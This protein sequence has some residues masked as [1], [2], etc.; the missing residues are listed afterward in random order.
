MKAS[1]QITKLQDELV[2]YA[3][4]GDQ[5][6][7]RRAFR[8]LLNAGCSRQEIVTKLL[9]ASQAAD[10]TPNA[11]RDEEPEAAKTEAQVS[12]SAQEPA[13]SDPEQNSENVAELPATPEPASEISARD[14]K[15]HP[16]IS[17]AEPAEPRPEGQPNLA[18]SIM[19]GS[20]KPD[21]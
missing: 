3:E 16:A 11:E 2:S 1:E 17:L 13:G 9:E 21:D 18:V 7:V 4:A 20:Q 5:D 15:P 8:E 14:E 12:G 10:Q 19:Q 6:A